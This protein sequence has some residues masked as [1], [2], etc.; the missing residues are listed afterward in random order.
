MLVRMGT[1][2]GQQ[3]ETQVERR[4]NSKSSSDGR[5]DRIKVEVITD[6]EANTTSLAPSTVFTKAERHTITWLIGCSMFFSPFTANIY[7]PCLEELQRAVLLCCQV[8]SNQNR[9]VEASHYIYAQNSTVHLGLGKK[10][11]TV[12]LLEHFRLLPIIR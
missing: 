3:E 1:R 2:E 12:T 4:R 9:E 7:F 10:P 6:V 5:D 8:L 11:M